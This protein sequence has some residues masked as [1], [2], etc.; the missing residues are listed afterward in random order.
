LLDGRRDAKFSV[1]KGRLIVAQQFTAGEIGDQEML[2]PVGTV[3]GAILRIVFNRPYGTDGSF[4]APDPAMNRWAIITR[5]YGAK[6]SRLPWVK[7][8]TPARV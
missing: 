5:P 3:E 6:R 8:L 7:V 2:R 4:I 1:P